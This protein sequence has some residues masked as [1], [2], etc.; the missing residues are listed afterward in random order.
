MKQH[1]F[2]PGPWA[3]ESDDL[4]ACY[5]ARLHEPCGNTPIATMFIDEGHDTM[6]ANA[7]LISAAPELLEAAE[8]I[9][10]E[11]HVLSGTGENNGH[12]GHRHINAL[13]QAIAKAIG[14]PK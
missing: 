1:K 13:K 3:I 9:L 2:T 10:R 6:R 8:L 14:G 11:V 7:R 4:D 5:V 12:I